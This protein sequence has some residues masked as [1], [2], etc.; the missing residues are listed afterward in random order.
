MEAGGPVG[1]VAQRSKGEE[2]LGQ[3]REGAAE[4]QGVI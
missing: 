4:G 1:R 3:P 2:T